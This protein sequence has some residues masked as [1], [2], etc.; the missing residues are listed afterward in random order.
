MT[1]SDSYSSACKSMYGFR[2]GSL[3]SQ[4]PV[5]MACLRCC[6]S[7]SGSVSVANFS[8]TQLR[9]QLESL[10]LRVSRLQSYASKTPLLQS[11]H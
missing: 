5:C 10:L 6:S 11:C 9:D 8:S 4:T 2:I 1:F 3:L 7:A